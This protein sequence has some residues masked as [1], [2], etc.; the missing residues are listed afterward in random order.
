MVAGGV[1]GNRSAGQTRVTHLLYA[2]GRR[3]LP[4]LKGG[5]KSMPAVAVPSIPSSSTSAAG[6]SDD[7]NSAE[8]AF[9]LQRAAVNAGIRAAICT[10]C[11]QVR[12]V[13]CTRSA[14]PWVVCP[15]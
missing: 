5:P 2:P 7:R 6:P 9:D 8:P 12:G 4:E 3:R 13:P 1:R 15:G 14:Y 10:P 11:P